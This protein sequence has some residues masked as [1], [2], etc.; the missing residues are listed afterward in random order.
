METLHAIAERLAPRRPVFVIGLDA[1]VEIDS[2]REPEALFATAHF[3]VMTRPPFSDATLRGSL[4]SCVRD[5]VRLADDGRSATHPAGTWIR[6]V[7]VTPLDV[8][9]SDIRRRL[10]QG[11][12]VRY[13]LPEAVHDAVASSGAYGP[14]PAEGAGAAGDA[15]E[16]PPGTLQEDPRA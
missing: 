13:L 14:P 5:A 16:E 4:P 11:R 7:P 9:A 3:A 8:S 6:L 2:W 1:F 10:R 15:T 12:S